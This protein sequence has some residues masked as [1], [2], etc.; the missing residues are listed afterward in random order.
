M[1]F[2]LWVVKYDTNIIFNKVLQ[3]MLL[4]MNITYKELDKLFQNI[5][6]SIQDGPKTNKLP[7]ETC[8]GQPLINF[9]QDI[10]SIFEF[11]KILEE[12][13]RQVEKYDL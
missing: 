4:V 12:K 5:K 1:C 11:G 6:Y 3:R 8:L 10:Q 13:I 7:H 9:L 2:D